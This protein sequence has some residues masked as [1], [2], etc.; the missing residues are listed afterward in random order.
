MYAQF[1]GL[2]REPFSIAPDPRYLFMSERHREALAHLL[3]GINAGGGFVLLTGEIG[4]GKTTVCHCFLEQIP[5]R[6]NVAYI[7]NPKLTVIELL[8]SVCDEFHIAPPEPGAVSGR[9]PTIKDYVD[10]LNDF[11]LQAH[12]IG[13]NNILIIDEAQNLSPD[14]LEQLRLLTNLETSKR[15]L[16]QVIL[17]GQP[18][19]RT[20]LERPE[21]EQL[22][23]RVIARYHLDALT[24]AET[25][26]YIR[27]RLA[28]AG[29]PKAN[30][31][32]RG[33]IRRIY[34]L[35][36]GVPRRIN[37]LCDRALL[38]GYAEGRTQ[39]DRAI[40]EK[41]AHEMFGRRARRAAGRRERARNLWLVGVGMAAGA[42][43]LG[44]L[45]WALNAD[46]PRQWREARFPWSKDVAAPASAPAAGV[47]VADLRPSPPAA[48][49]GPNGAAS[50]SEAASLEGPPSLAPATAAAPPPQ[51][52]TSMAE[53]VVPFRSLQR[54][55]K[56]AWRELA[57]LW[58]VSLGSG[59]PC[60]AA[61]KQQLRCFR[62]NSSLTTIR[63]L[64]RP[65][66]LVLRDENDQAA[67][68][69]LT[70]LTSQS[71]TLRVDGISRT[72]SLVT[73][74]KV[75]RG[76]YATLWRTPRG[77]VSGAL[78]DSPGPLADWLWT[79]LARAQGQ[80][81]P[82]KTANRDRAALRAR[83]AAFQREYGLEADGLAGPTTL[84]QLN[85]GIGV[86]EPRLQTQ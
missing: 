66:I 32:D 9:S 61:L 70:G 7:F 77:Y 11:L 63:Q 73:L 23:Q 8:Q 74:A 41:A 55:E 71:A 54:D 83:V 4:A 44:L 84:M 3:Y 34:R 51:P 26:E 45:A 64:G 46:L 62:S 22:A 30:L 69:L 40:V 25:V 50:A 20:M 5:K 21:L 35:S 75:W 37:L 86:D 65:G 43:V 6:C 53:P 52:A 85:R 48:A 1:F 60:Q 33:A 78:D 72:V 58:K 49:Q 67:Y 2:K 12:A 76:D 16:L 59:D 56:Q 17:I 38:G 24:E 19:L 18:E 81:Q 80:P 28:V 29:L 14:V 68:A 10:R 13:Q 15:K 82:A 36:R 47:A 42:M 31:F 27:H 57:P 39:V 79:Q